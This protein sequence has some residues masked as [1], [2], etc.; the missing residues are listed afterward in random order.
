M[1]SRV[2][3]LFVKDVDFDF[4]GKAEWGAVVELHT[5]EIGGQDIVGFAGGNTLGE[6]AVVVGV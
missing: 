4:F 6:F 5:F 1:Q 2:F 3:A